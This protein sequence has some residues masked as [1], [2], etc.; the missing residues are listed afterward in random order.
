MALNGIMFGIS[1]LTVVPLV[2]DLFANLKDTYKDVKDFS[3]VRI[4]MG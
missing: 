4:G 1:A 3:I 2:L